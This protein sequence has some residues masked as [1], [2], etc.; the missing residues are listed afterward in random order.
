MYRVL[1]GS[2]PG[3]FLGA[4]AGSF[5]DN[6]VYY[7]VGTA[8]GDGLAYGEYGFHSYNGFGFGDTYQGDGQGGLDTDS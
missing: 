7:L 8:D 5:I 4:T 2:V 6:S 3:E 1:R